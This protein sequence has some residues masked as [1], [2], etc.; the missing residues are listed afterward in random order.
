MKVT[1]A[2]EALRLLPERA[3]LWPAR[4]A[5][6]LADVHVGKVEAFQRFGVALPSEFGAAELERLS[7]LVVREAVNAVWV[8]GD[9]FHT[10]ADSELTLLAGLL[11]RHP[12]V[13][14]HLIAGNHDR[15]LSTLAQIGPLE[16]HPSAAV[17][18]PFMLCH[19]PQRR[20]STYVLAGHLHPMVRLRSAGDALRLP[21]FQFQSS[22]G[23][24]P[25]FTEFSGGLPVNRRD[26]RTFAIAGSEVVEV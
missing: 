9:L 1:V 24:L 17:L 19:E 16:V 14:F 18:G 25:A 13:A 5:L 15:R 2:G 3:V 26:G 12:G 20:T 4:R 11:T 23:L 21:C 7:A 8:L 6:L 22:L 10:A